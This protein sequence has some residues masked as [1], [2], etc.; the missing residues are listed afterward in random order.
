MTHPAPPDLAAPP[1]AP[2]SPKL[3][4]WAF[5]ALLILC[6]WPTI[7]MTSRV[8]VFSEDMAHG[9]FAPI[10]AAYITWLK[11]GKLL[12]GTQPSLSGLPVLL[13]AMAIALVATLGNSSTF[14]R[15]ALLLSIAGV[16]LIVG[17]YQLFRRLLFP[18][19]L[20]FFTFPVPAVL[21]GELT[22]PLQLLATR[23]SESCFELLGLSVVRDGNILELAHQRLS[24][25]EACSGIR[26]LIT[27]FFF[28]TVYAYFGESRPG[29]RLILATAAVPA[30]ISVNVLRIV[31][32]G[33]IT[34][35]NPKYAHG[36]YHDS[37]GWAAFLVGFG[38]VFLLHRLATKPKPLNI[39]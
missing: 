38:I 13:V 36:I 6:Y 35:V 2:R 28:C 18:W 29:W 22:L 37:L 19:L 23:L 14:S 21:Y 30:A 27:L 15:F 11:R 5:P 39:Y 26:S 3:I 1:S 34:K 4:N 33:L 16:L 7:M 17:G 8:L 32:T 10:V 24:V 20:L 25:V 31:S 12:Q 9:L